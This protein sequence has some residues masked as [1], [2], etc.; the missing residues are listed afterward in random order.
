MDNFQSTEL[1]AIGVDIR[2]VNGNINRRLFHGD[3]LTI[4]DYETEIKKILQEQNKPL[5]IHG[6][7]L[8]TQEDLDRKRTQ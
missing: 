8:P 4:P 3:I 6:V 7:R 2:T 1:Q 5:W